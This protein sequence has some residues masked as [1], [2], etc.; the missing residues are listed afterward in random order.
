[1]QARRYEQD[2]S[3]GGAVRLKKLLDACESDRLKRRGLRPEATPDRAANVRAR[4]V[5][6][7]KQIGETDDA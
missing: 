7:D 3:A 5:S 1:M 6:L 4:I 2:G